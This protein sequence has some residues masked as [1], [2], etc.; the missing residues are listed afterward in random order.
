[1]TPN[2]AEKQTNNKQRKR[3]FLE[4]SHSPFA[5][6]SLPTLRNKTDTNNTD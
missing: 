4:Q 5:R 2:S 3:S 6:F 1:M